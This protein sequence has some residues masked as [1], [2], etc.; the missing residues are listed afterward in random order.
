MPIT[1]LMPALS[2][3]M[4]EGNLARWLKNEGDSVAPGDVIAEIE[5]DKATMEVES[6]DEGVLGKILE[7][8]RQDGGAGPNLRL[9]ALYVDQ[10]PKS[11]KSR[12]LAEKYGFKIAST[13]EEAVLAAGDDLAGVLSIGEHGDYP[14][15]PKTKQRTAMLT[16][17]VSIPS[18]SPPRGLSAPPGKSP[19]P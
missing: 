14:Y 18:A 12:G 9:A 6:V 19:V 11:D 15:T 8:Y 13:I 5:T 4:T 3:T 1:I 7:G 10:F 17:A 16:A 2:P